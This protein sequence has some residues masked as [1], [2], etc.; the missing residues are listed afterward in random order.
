MFPLNS[1]M[2]AWHPNTFKHVVPV[3]RP[4]SNQNNFESLCAVTVYLFFRYQIYL[5][6]DYSFSE[7]A[8]EC[9]DE[10]LVTKGAL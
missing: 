7:K 8:S 6:L 10:A 9:H 2:S 4:N 5:T 1:F 3:N